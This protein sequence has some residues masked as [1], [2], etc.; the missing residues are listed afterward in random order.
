MSS[1]TNFA[2]TFFWRLYKAAVDELY[3]IWKP[4]RWKKGK[5]YIIKNGKPVGKDKFQT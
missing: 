1:T 3:H 5:V 4:V 2:I